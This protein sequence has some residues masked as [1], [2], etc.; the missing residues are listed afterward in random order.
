M[1]LNQKSSLKYWVAYD[2]RDGDILLHTASKKYND[3]VRKL[4]D[5]FG[6]GVIAD[7][8]YFDIILIEIKRVES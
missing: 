8:D 3:A 2:E 5:Q 1:N 6:V 4:E 7:V